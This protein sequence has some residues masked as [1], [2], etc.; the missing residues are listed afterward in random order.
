M[1]KKVNFGLNFPTLPFVRCEASWRKVQL[2]E[3]TVQNPE[4]QCI[5]LSLGRGLK[6]G[7]LVACSLICKAGN[8][9]YPPPAV[10]LRPL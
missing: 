4:R 7:G 6:Q 5:V 10:G 2:Y 8:L 1:A 9:E 3:Q